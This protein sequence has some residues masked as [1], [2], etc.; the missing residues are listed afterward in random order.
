M[1]KQ[2]IFIAFWLLGGLTGFAQTVTEP[3]IIRWDSSAL[4][5]G[6]TLLYRDTTLMLIGADAS[7]G[8]FVG[9]LNDSLEVVNKV[10]IN[11]D[12]GVTSASYRFGS[13][14]IGGIR[15][16]GNQI[17]SLAMNRINEAGIK[18]AGGRA[19]LEGTFDFAHGITATQ[20]SGAVV[21]GMG[22]P[23]RV[24]NLCKFDQAGGI[25]WNKKFAISPDCYANDVLEADNGDLFVTGYAGG[26]QAT[27]EGVFLLK[28]NSDG[29]SIWTSTLSNPGASG[30][31]IFESG[32]KE[33]LVCGT[34]YTSSTAIAQRPYLYLSK[35][36]SLGK[37][38]WEITYPRFVED[39]IVQEFTFED[40]TPTSDGGVLFLATAGISDTAIQGE[41]PYLLKVDAQGQYQW[42]KI[43]SPA[44]GDQASG[45]QVLPLRNGTYG[46]MLIGK[47]MVGDPYTIY[48][49]LGPDGTFTD[50]ER[51][52]LNALAL[53]LT[54]NPADE[55]VAVAWTQA[56]AGLAEVRLLD[57]QG[58]LLHSHQLTQPAG[59]VRLEL[60]IEDLP[61]G[62]YLVEVVTGG[63]VGTAKLVKQ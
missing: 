45:L 15:L 21:F 50:L 37:V 48:A 10:Y 53:S 20:D 8:A 38:I 58:R 24:I 11:A 56:S 47:P 57:V 7:Q 13:Y 18:E 12:L 42:H 22:S 59:P 30:K 60:P 27:L 28:L 33:M 62:V 1:N 36:D 54:P 9:E 49:L 44:N 39:D 2:L 16:L 25:S 17:Y 31:K 43:L 61:A 26:F 51:P 34:T 40:A 5:I 55:T 35:I 4:Q 46:L 3:A 29:D 23:P 41:R 19:N 6:S 32:K 63:K 14:Y 52:A